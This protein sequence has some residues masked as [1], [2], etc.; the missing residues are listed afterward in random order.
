MACALSTSFNMLI[1]FRFL[2]GMIGAAPMTVG[3]GTI[4]DII[5]PQE[6]GFAMMIW[7][8]GVVLGPVIGPIVGGFLS[9]A[10]GWRWLFWLV[11][12][13]AGASSVA[14]IIFL[15]ET[16]PSV[17]LERKTR[18][19]RKET[20][21]MKFRSKL[22]S[23][24]TSKGL[25]IRAIV[26]PFKMLFLSPICGLLCIYNAFIYGVV[27]I[28]LTSFT[29][30]MEDSYGFNRGS[31]GLIYIGIGIG[32]VAGMVSYGMVSDRIVKHLMKRNGDGRP[33]PEYRLINTLFGAPFIPVGL[34][35]Y[36]WTAQYEIQ[37]AVPLLGTLLIGFG[38][39]T[40][41]AS[42]ANYMIDAF[43]I[44]AAGAMAALTVSRSIFGATFPLFVLHLY[45]TL[46]YGWGNSLLAFL[47]LAMVPIP[48]LFY[49]YGE[50]LRTNPRFQVKL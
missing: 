37:W 19:L 24:L 33:K 38:F 2:A 20:G 44:H 47:A 21:N 16:N 28:F 22:D 27:Y 5:P 18:K 10:R 48:A 3:G 12:I 35:I 1:A 39:T 17:L 11:V 13:V 14:G 23:G 49:R 36:G 29:F 26:R 43:T 9:Q 40:I 4:G 45:D 6:R 41:M 42:I 46:N 31:L 30:V 50:R 7:N 34:F 25:F 8:M 15:R 32:L